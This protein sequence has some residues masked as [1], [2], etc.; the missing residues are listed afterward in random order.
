MVTIKRFLA[1]PLNLG[2][3]ALAIL[4]IAGAA[5][6]QANA[7]TSPTAPVS[8]AARVED[9]VR[10]FFG[11]FAAPSGDTTAKRADDLYAKGVAAEQAGNLQEALR[12]YDMALKL[13][14]NDPRVHLAIGRILE[15][16]NPA[17]SLYHYQC[18]F[19]FT[20]D[21]AADKAPTVDITRRFLVGRYLQ[22]ALPIDLEKPDVSVKLLELASS[23]APE[24]PRIHAHLATAYFHMKSYERSI[25]E[26]RNALTLGLDDGLIFTN[27]AAAFAQLRKKDETETML[28]TSLERDEM[29]INEA[30]NAIRRSNR[31]DTLITF[32]KVLGA[33]RVKDLMENSTKGRLEAVLLAWKDKKMDDAVKLAEAAVAGNPYH[34]YSLIVL[35]DFKRHMGDTEGAKAAY[36]KAL[37][38]NPANQLAYPRLGD[39]T[40]SDGDFVGAAENYMKAMDV[41]S[42]RLERIDI[43]DRTAVA[44]ARNGKHDQALMLLDRWLR[45]NP[46]APEAFELNIRRAGILTDA[47]RRTEAEAVLKRLID[48]D[49]LNPAAY[50]ALYTYYDQREERNKARSI[51]NEGIIRIEAARD[52]DPLNPTFYRDLARMYRV[53]NSE[54]KA[55]QELLNGGL[56]TGEKRFFSNAL[57]A[58]DAETEAFQVLQSWIAMEPRNPEALLSH[59][60]VAAKLNR[61]VSLALA[62]VEMV[63]K[64]NPGA[65]I[66]PVRRTRAY[67]NYTLKNYAR[68]IDD[69]K[70]FLTD[71]SLPQA[72]FFHRLWGLSAEALGKKADAKTH[73]KKAMELDS[74]S[75]EDLSARIAALDSA[76][77]R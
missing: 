40:F 66:A 48:K 59:G 70:A 9:A 77:G 46:D 3:A 56:R 12:N 11:I 27:L 39:I 76:S 14:Y 5:L 35:G 61:D 52:K 30:L 29:D 41:M 26:S 37:E 22:Y 32:D 18:A 7:V 1:V 10:T 45:A 68:T 51:V 57:F 17:L 47:N 53:I 28:I 65:D 33:A 44:L 72:A 73:F 21:A 36:K 8:E 13:R 67:L 25:M 60:W 19:R 55:R 64:D 6:A 75:N 43:L 24:D 71:D 49:K 54:M 69:I 74:E 20:I 34:S 58:S 31:S 62:N 63:A 50:V 2:S 38:R 23:L 42:G 4:F 16:N 15:T